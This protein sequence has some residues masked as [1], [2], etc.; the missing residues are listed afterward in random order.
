MRQIIASEGVAFVDSDHV[1]P[2]DTSALQALGIEFI[3]EDKKG[4]WYER[5][6]FR[7]PERDIEAGRQAAEA[8]FAEAQQKHQ[9]FLAEEQTGV[10]HSDSGVPRQVSSFQA[11]AAMDAVILPDGSSLL[12]AVEAYMEDPSTPKIEKL[13]FRKARDFERASPLVAKI[14]SQFGLTDAQVDNLFIEAIKIE[15]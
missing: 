9:A 3:G 15:V 12:D 2:V 5:V 6:P 1:Y 4:L 10:E 13:A 11:F 7:G 14:A 8:I